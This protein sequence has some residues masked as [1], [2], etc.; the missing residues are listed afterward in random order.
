MART[1]RPVGDG[2]LVSAKESRIRR[3][4]ASIDSLV[5]V[6]AGLGT[7]RDKK[8]YSDYS[9]PYTLTRVQLENIFRASWAGKRIVKAIPEDMTREWVSFLWDGADDDIEGRKTLKQAEQDFAVRSKVL[10]AETWASLYGGAAIVMGIVGDETPEAMAKPLRVESLRRGC[11]RYLHVLDRW[12]LG[13]GPELVTDLGDPD[14]GQPKFYILAES[15]IR[16]HRSRMVIFNGERLPWF[17]WRSNAMWHDSVLQH[18]YD[19]L[20]NY[21]TVTS[22]LATMMFEQNIDVVANDQVTEAL[23]MDDGEAALVRRY[24]GMALM[25][26]VNRLVLIDKEHE[27][28]DRKQN[29][30][31]GMDKVGEKFMF[32][33]CGAADIPF[34][35]LFGQ[36]PAGM[37]STGESDMR[38]YYDRVKAKQESD[39]LPQL[40]RLMSVLVRHALGEWPTDFRIECNPLYQMSAV[41]KMNVQKVRAERDQINVQNGFVTEGVVTAQ[42]KEDG[43]YSMLEDDDVDA[44]RELSEPMGP[45]A[46]PTGEAAKTG[47]VKAAALTPTA[48][49]GIITV[50]EARRMQGL[51]DWPDADGGL[52]ILEFQAKHGGTVAAAVNAEAGQTGEADKADDVPSEKMP[53]VE[54]ES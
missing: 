44:A 52:T 2:V 46:A 11:L 53:P 19:N 54:V 47:A 9:F 23:T 21:D 43:V 37:N 28:Y 42:L 34:T 38:N 18:I 12:R 39:M 25:K 22:A 51:T 14:F 8:Y 15:G 45:G 50:N 35:R 4:L 13:A 32:D 36:A 5:N 26:S 27:T 3:G 31:A 10:D 29:S 17:L 1:E 6:V 30:F 33:L 40:Y 41:E 24:Q 20:R 48:M 16:V 7:D 49:A